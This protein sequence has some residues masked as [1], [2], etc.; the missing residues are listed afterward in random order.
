MPKRSTSKT[1][2]YFISPDYGERASGRAPCPTCVAHETIMYAQGAKRYRSPWGEPWRSHI[3]S[4]TLMC[5]AGKVSCGCSD[6]TSWAAA[7]HTDAHC[8]PCRFEQSPSARAGR[9]GSRRRWHGPRA[10][11]GGCSAP[12]LR[13]PA[14][15]GL[16]S[17]AARSPLRATQ[18]RVAARNTH[19]CHL[20]AQHASGQQGVALAPQSPHIAPVSFPPN[21]DP[22]RH[23]RNLPAPCGSR[24]RVKSSATATSRWPRRGG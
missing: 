21:R 6:D 13:F 24:V 15:A 3:S 22:L 14:I 12:G 18:G 17:V 20:P 9:G 7:G 10:E 19:A 11:R 16:E 2:A 23:P 1:V 4:N 8:P 5:A